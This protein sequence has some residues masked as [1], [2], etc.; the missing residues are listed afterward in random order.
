VEAVFDYKDPDVSK[1]LKDASNGKI[2]ICLDGISEYGSTKLAAAAL[3]DEGGTI[4]TLCEP[5][6]FAAARR[7]IAAYMPTIMFSASQG[8]TS[9]GHQTGV[10]T[11]LPYPRRQ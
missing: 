10:P 5:T 3:S 7:S 8:R 2:K 9:S 11:S 4:A 1:K 6:L